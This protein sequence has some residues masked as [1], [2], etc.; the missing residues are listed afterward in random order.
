M[1]QLFYRGAF[2]TQLVVSKIVH[3]VRGNCSEL[4]LEV[5]VAL[6]LLMLL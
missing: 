1:F 3:R 4:S 2:C 5:L 6:A